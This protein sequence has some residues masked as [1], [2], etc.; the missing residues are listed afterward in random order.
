[1]SRRNPAARCRGRRASLARPAAA[2][3]GVPA[4]GRGRGER[5]VRPGSAG[6]FCADRIVPAAPRAGAARAGPFRRPRRV[7]QRGG[8]IGRGLVRRTKAVL[9]RRRPCFRMQTQGPTVLPRSYQEEPQQRPVFFLRETPVVIS[10][11][12]CGDDSIH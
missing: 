1:M 7:Y 4:R 6:R 11:R 8:E 5:L 10:T 9:L 3:A 2:A 12:F